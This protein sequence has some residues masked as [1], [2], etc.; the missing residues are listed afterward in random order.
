MND[1]ITLRGVPVF[2]RT[3]ELYLV[4][5]DCDISFDLIMTE[6]PSG[7][8]PEGRQVKVNRGRPRA[9]VLAAWDLLIADK[10][11]EEGGEKA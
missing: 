3:V 10:I 4:E 11:E 9:A 2:T 8:Y 1:K 6:D 5:R 7:Q